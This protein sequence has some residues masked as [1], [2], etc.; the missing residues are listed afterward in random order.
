MVFYR[1]YRPQSIGELDST[2]VRET[3]F[4]VLSVKSVPHAFLFTGPKGLGKTS[5]ARIIAKVVNCLD[6]QPAK[7]FNNVKIEPDN[8]CEQCVSITNGTN[9]DVIEIDGASNRGID[10][11]RDLREKVKLAPSTAKKKVYIIDE[12]HMLTTEAFNALLKTIEEPPAHV[13]FVFCTTEP[14][15]VPATILSRCFHIAFA[16]ATEDELVHAL[17][18][19]VH[20][21]NLQIDTEALHMI[22]R[23]AEGG[24]RDATK[25]LE[26][27]VAVSNGEK[28]TQEIV[29]KQYHVSSISYYVL[30]LLENLEK[31]D[32]KSCL[33][34]IQKITNDGIDNK[35]FITEILNALHQILLAKIN[36]LHNTK[37]MLHNTSIEDIQTLVMLFSEAYQQ[38]K[39]AVIPQLPLEMAVVAYGQIQDVGLQV[40]ED[41]KNEILHT[42]AFIQN[43][44]NKPTMSSLIKKQHVMKVNAILRP[45]TT[46][47]DSGQKEKVTYGEQ[48]DIS[49]AS[50]EPKVQFMENLIYKVKPL[51]HSLAGVLR[52]CKVIEIGEDTVQLEAG[53]AFHK[54]RLEEKQSYEIIEKAVKELTGKN[55]K[56]KINLRK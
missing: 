9:L 43:D 39:F 40:K 42:T 34:I 29:E 8:S 2:K 14:H 52:G 51:N 45:Q 50:S 25:I 5:T 31:K 49:H 6:P 38:T 22:A 27:L 44:N 17:T 41:K 56:I 21:E 4:A 23:M 37:Y 10:E 11:I 1:K 26:E 55:L 16:L 15:K 28:I 48:S 46:P 19:I 35:Y 20:G 3:L 18:R 36:I 32:V 13:M 47:K 12:V 7:E 33:E 24:F 30:S 53:Y 54:E